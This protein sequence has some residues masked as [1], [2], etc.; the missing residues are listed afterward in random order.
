MFRCQIPS[1]VCLISNRLGEEM[2]QEMLFSH[3]VSNRWTGSLSKINR[4]VL[5][6]WWCIIWT[7]TVSTATMKY[8]S[9]N[10]IWGIS[11]HQINKQWSQWIRCNNRFINYN[12][13]SCTLK[14]KIELWPRASIF[15]ICILRDHFLHNNS[16]SNLCRDRCPRISWDHQM[17]NNNIWTYQTTLTTT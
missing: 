7:S 15:Q 4:Q 14:A 13:T 11:L 2:T 8:R 10:Y 5:L 12:S 3:L 1:W 16:N 6:E 17:G 9:N